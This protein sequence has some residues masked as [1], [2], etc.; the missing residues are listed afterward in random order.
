MD[1]GGEGAKDIDASTVRGVF[2]DLQLVRLDGRGQR[3][4]KAA[5]TRT[6]KAWTVLKCPVIAGVGGWF[7]CLF[8]HE[9]DIVSSL[10]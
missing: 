4:G 9:S 3:V 8:C 1:G 2:G 6:V 10:C 7:V 5:A